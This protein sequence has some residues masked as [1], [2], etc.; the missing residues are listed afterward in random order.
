MVKVIECGYLRAE[1]DMTNINDP[2]ITVSTIQPVTVSEYHKNNDVWRW[3]GD[4]A[5][6]ACG[7]YAEVNSAIFDERQRRRRERLLCA[8]S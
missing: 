4:L 6:D 1:V 2:K 5:V 3:G 8:V 7:L